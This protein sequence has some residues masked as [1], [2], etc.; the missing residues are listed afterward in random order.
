MGYPVLVFFFKQN[1]TNK[2]GH[3]LGGTN[4]T[5]Q[6]PDFGSLR[7]GLIDP[8]TP[9]DAYTKMNIDGTKKMN[10]VFSDEFEQDGRS[11]YPGDDPIWSAENVEYWE[12]GDMEWY[13]PAAI[14]TVGGAL[15]ISLTEHRSHNKNFRSGMLNSWNKFCFTGGRVEVAVTLPGTNDVSGFWPAAWLMG[16]IGRAVGIA[17]LCDAF[18]LDADRSC[19]VLSCPIS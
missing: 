10:L 12:T 1:H 11:F 16:N 14:T 13:D 5:G 4:A 17:C 6:V 2:E 18:D 7:S 15:R 8:D 9:K 3:G 19:P